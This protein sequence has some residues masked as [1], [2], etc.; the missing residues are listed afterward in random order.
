[1]TSKIIA[2]GISVNN[3]YTDEMKHDIHRLGFDDGLLKYGLMSHQDHGN[4][5]CVNGKDL[6]MYD[7]V[8]VNGKDLHMYEN[9]LGWKIVKEMKDVKTISL[10]NGEN[11][12][13]DLVKGTKITIRGQAKLVTDGE[14][15]SITSNGECTVEIEKTYF[16]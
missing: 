10:E 16:E 5:V 12:T 11:F 6:R 14:K 4:V 9:G 2:D 13:I 7:V 15:R 8:C 3:D 1:M